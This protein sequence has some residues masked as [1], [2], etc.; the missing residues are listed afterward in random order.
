MS[1]LAEKPKTNELYDTDF[2]LW[3][4]EQARLLRDKRWND[5][6]LEN[7]AGEVESVG[8]SLKRELES[9]LEIILAH[10]LKW[11][12][13]P[14]Y[15]GKSWRTTLW[16][17]RRQIHKL[18]ATAP[19]LKSNTADALADAYV[20]ATLEAE[21]QTGIDVAVF[22]GSCPFTLE[23]ALDQD[24]FPPDLG[25]DDQSGMKKLSQKRKAQK[26]PL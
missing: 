25:F 2:F 18:I 22:P 23:Q 13:Q 14:G 9:R 21:K 12:Y 5:L 10:L 15:Q 16:E 11:R 20:A 6:D 1:K 26:A 8:I 24:F 19:S 7:L 17:Q 3:T 4:Q